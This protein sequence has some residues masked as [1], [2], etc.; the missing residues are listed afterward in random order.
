MAPKKAASVINA[1]KPT[2]SE[3]LLKQMMATCEKSRGK[4]HSLSSIIA[5]LEAEI[6]ELV[7]DAG[8]LEFRV[9][10]KVASNAEYHTQIAKV[11]AVL[12]K[13][14]ALYAYRAQTCYQTVK[15]ARNKVVEDAAK[16]KEYKE[17]IKQ[18]RVPGYVD[19]TKLLVSSCV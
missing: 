7:R 1:S 18:L 13:L 10:S 14:D 11:D 4:G 2:P 17:R 3:Q 5:N 6:R 15:D 16:L 9:Q 19:D 12:A 8:M